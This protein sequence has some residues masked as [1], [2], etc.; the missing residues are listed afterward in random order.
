MNTENVGRKRNH[1]ATV[2]PFVSLQLLE[3]SVKWQIMISEINLL[4]FFETISAIFLQT[5]YLFSY[6]ISCLQKLA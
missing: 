2:T 1:L 3:S 6:A 5:K 4:F